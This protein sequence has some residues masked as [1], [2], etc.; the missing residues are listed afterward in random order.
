MTDKSIHTS[1][2]SSA[3]R[4]KKYKNQ[5]VLSIWSRYKNTCPKPGISRP[6]KYT[7]VCEN[8]IYI[9]GK[10]FVTLYTFTYMYEIIISR[11]TREMIN[12]TYFKIHD[13]ATQKRDGQKYRRSNLEHFEFTV[14]IHVDD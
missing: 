10:V 9:Y 5:D 14:L 7:K 13:G 6:S 11:R 8:I 12:C 3:M 4:Y 1:R 2:F